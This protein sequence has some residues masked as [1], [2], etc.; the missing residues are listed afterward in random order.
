[1]HTVNKHEV[2]L[3]IDNFTLVNLT[4]AP[5]ASVPC[6]AVARIGVDLV[7]AHTVR[8]AGNF[9]AVVD[10]ELARVAS[11]SSY[12][13]ASESIDLVEASRS[14]LARIIHA[15]VDVDLAIGPLPPWHAVAGV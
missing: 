7:G 13:V 8:T 6:A 1:L 12:A 10:I 2:S 15:V 5:R 3:R 9:E 4:A 14:I 11:K